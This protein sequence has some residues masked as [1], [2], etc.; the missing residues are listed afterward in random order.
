MEKVLIAVLVAFTAA[1]AGC[2]APQVQ[3]LDEALSTL[4]KHGR[5]GYVR[6][7]LPLQV[8]AGLRQSAYVG[9]PGWVEA[10]FQLREAE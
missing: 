3:T 5:S 8:E 7:R 9:S 4:Q 6:V 2:R 1:L 10:E